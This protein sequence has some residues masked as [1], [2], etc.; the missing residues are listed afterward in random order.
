MHAMIAEDE[1][2]AQ[3]IHDDEEQQLLNKLRVKPLAVEQQQSLN[4]PRWSLWPYDRR[5]TLVLFSGL[6]LIAVIAV[7][8]A[9]YLDGNGGLSTRSIPFLN[10]SDANAARYKNTNYDLNQLSSSSATGNYSYDNMDYNGNQDEKHVLFSD[11]NEENEGGEYGDDYDYDYEE[12]DDD[13]Q[14]DDDDDDDD[15][16]D[17][18]EEEEDEGGK[19]NTNNLLEQNKD[20]QSDNKAADHKDDDGITDN[21][22]EHAPQKDTGGQNATD[23]PPDTKNTKIER[24]KDNQNDEER[25]RTDDASEEGQNASK[26][27]AERST[28][29]S[30]MKTSKLDYDYD[31]EPQLAENTWDE[32][33]TK[34][35]SGNQQEA[36]E[37]MFEDVA[38]SSVPKSTEDLVEYDDYDDD[39]DDG[40]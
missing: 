5:K 39:D 6:V 16:D 34:N 11:S 28:S 17:E 14:V 24:G 22:T 31:Y 1:L 32:N 8:V 10:R 30:E 9:F 13:D 12:G 25:L 29:H 37:A 7:G 40:Q 35:I 36:T 15:D 19:K 33:N 4:Q 38:T 21:N 23:A 26:A 3:G 2:K 27:P 18:K 20:E